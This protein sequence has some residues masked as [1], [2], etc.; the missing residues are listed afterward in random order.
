MVVRSDSHGLRNSD[1]CEEPKVE[2]NG[3]GCP[4]PDHWKYLGCNSC[5]NKTYLLKGAEAIKLTQK[6][7][8]LTLN[9]NPN[10]IQFYEDSP[11]KPHLFRLSLT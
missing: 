7:R 2:I 11:T 8:Q 6:T 4:T 5:P 9:S 1:A 3:F 10:S